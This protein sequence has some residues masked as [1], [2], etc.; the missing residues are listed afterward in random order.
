M[1]KRRRTGQ[2]RCAAETIKL[3]KGVAQQWREIGTVHSFSNDSEIAAFLLQVYEKRGADDSASSSLCIQCNQPLPRYLCF[4]CNAGS[5]L[6]AST[7]ATQRAKTTSVKPAESE[8]LAKT[9][10]KVEEEESEEGDLGGS[11]KRKRNGLPAKEVY[12][13]VNIVAVKVE[14]VIGDGED[15]TQLLSEDD[16]GSTLPV[17]FDDDQTDPSYELPDEADLTDEASDPPPQPHRKRKPGGKAKDETAEKY[18][19]K[20]CHATFQQAYR[21]K[22]HS[23]IHAADHGKDRL[24]SCEQC[25]MT[26]RLKGSLDAHM[27]THSGQQLYLCAICNLPFTQPKQTK[28]HVQSQHPDSFNAVPCFKCATCQAEFSLYKKFTTHI[29]RHTLERKFQCEYCSMAFFEPSSLRVHQRVHT[30]DKPFT[31]SECGLSFHQ[32]SNLNRHVLTHS[33]ERPYR[34]TLCPATY[35]AS[36]QLKLHLQSHRGEKPF[37]C[38]LCGA[39]YTENKS[40]K[41]HIRSHTGEKPYKCDQCDKEFARPAS[42]RVH[43][44]T[45]SSDRPYVCALCGASFS[46]NSNLHRHHRLKHVGKPKK[47][48]SGNSGGD[49]NDGK[50]EGGSTDTVN[51][52]AVRGFGFPHNGGLHNSKTR[53]AE[54][55]ST[56]PEM[57]VNGLV[58]DPAGG[59]QGQGTHVSADDGRGVAVVGGVGQE[60]RERVVAGQVPVL[61]AASLMTY[62]HSAVPSAVPFPY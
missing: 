33:G 42:L 21:L 45:H 52:Q 23:K 19:C 48:H 55:Q 58:T 9:E 37:L 47:R 35:P 40:L 36:Q 3:T 54:L 8:E 61:S 18:E 4:L 7:T 51:V 44:R 62:T 22:R 59:V 25:R 5:R 31:C 12:E 53:S 43:K 6:A 32:L 10:V 50:A 56:V 14:E 1:A 29:W 26:F 2:R 60:R 57:G 15:V 30:G 11:R 24:Y 17:A 41:F 27:R 38:Q 39:S 20:H 49:N 46:D 34:C 13:G 28:K 16:E